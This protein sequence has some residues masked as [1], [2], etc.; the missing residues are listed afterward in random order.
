MVALPAMITLSEPP[1]L[2]RP[3]TA[4]RTSYLT[5]EQ[6]D[7]L[8]RGTDTDWLGPASTDFD[9]FVAARDHDKE[10]WD[11]MSTVYWYVSEEHY[12]GTLVVRH[13]LTPDLAVDG[14]HIGYHVVAPWR[15]QGHA[16]RML[17]LGLEKAREHGVSRALLTCVPSNEPS[18]RVIEKNGGVLDEQLGNELRF[19]IG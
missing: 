19:W 6:A 5:G 2:V 9:A 12:L 8:L 4:V 1:R 15:R 14:G 3:R 17:E 11:V 13:T 18:R 10:R 7:C 16:T